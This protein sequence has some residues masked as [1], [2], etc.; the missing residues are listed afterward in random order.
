MRYVQQ[1]INNFFLKKP[2]KCKLFSSV[3][4]N[5]IKHERKK[6]S[7]SLQQ[8]IDKCA[9]VLFTK[10]YCHYSQMAKDAIKS[11]Q[12]LFGDYEN[13]KRLVII[14]IDL[15]LKDAPAASMEALQEDLRRLTGSRTVPR[16]FAYKRDEAHSCFLGDGTTIATLQSQGKLE[17]ILKQAIQQFE[18]K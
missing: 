10:S 8:F 18:K 2:V 1:E 4:K 6:M 17:A 9:V 15:M 16:V 3:S 13:N 7:S 11:N 12:S 14:D 5:N